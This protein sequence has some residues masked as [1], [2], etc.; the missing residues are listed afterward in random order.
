MYVSQPHLYMSVFLEL[1]KGMVLALN[2]FRGLIV[3]PEFIIMYWFTNH[4]NF[5]H[6]SM[7]SLL[8]YL[9]NS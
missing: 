3:N 7:R 9:L 4:M 6:Q 1:N 2:I 5:N 8:F